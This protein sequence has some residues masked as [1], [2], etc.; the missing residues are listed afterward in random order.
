M[1]K[2]HYLSC[3]RRINSPRE[4][5]KPDSLTPDRNELAKKHQSTFSPNMRSSQQ[6]LTWWYSTNEN[7]CS[8]EIKKKK[9]KSFFSIRGLV[10]MKPSKFRCVC[11]SPTKCFG[12]KTILHKEQG[13]S[14]H[15]NSDPLSQE[16]RTNISTHSRRTYTSFCRQSTYINWI[17]ALNLV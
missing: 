8:R 2:I 11:K 12:R 16:I 7:R 9:R 4:W 3:L 17:N 13:E 5:K 6:T 10:G 15:T 1:I 14:R